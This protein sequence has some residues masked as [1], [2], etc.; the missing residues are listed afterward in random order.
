MIPNTYFHILYVQILS[1]DQNNLAIVTSEP[2]NYFKGYVTANSKDLVFARNDFLRLVGSPN[3]SLILII[4]YY[5]FKYSVR[6]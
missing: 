2:K 5:M 3:E 4:I 6:I 1:W